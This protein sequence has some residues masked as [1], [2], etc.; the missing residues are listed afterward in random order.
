MENRPVS[1]DSFFRWTD[2]NVWAEVSCL[3]VSD[4]SD[5]ASFLT[6]RFCGL[7]AFHACRPNSLE[8]YL[9]DG[10]RYLSRSDLNDYAI[11]FFSGTQQPPDA[12]LLDDIVRRAETGAIGVCLAIDDRELR[13]SRFATHGS[14][15][16]YRIAILLREATG[17]DYVAA[18]G[19]TGSPTLIMVGLPWDQIHDDDRSEVAFRMASEIGTANSRQS[20]VP[21]IDKCLLID[22]TLPAERFLSIESL[23]CPT[24]AMR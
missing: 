1:V 16:C 3:G 13:K 17:I 5:L 2:Q 15:F 10:I 4:A 11:D 19:T 23:A 14:E 7:A 9:S 12:E 21:A 8:S 20:I 18:L 22:R 24:L 6:T